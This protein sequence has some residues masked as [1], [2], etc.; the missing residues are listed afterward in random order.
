MQR[1][2]ALRASRPDIAAL[3]TSFG[4]S[5]AV[6]AGLAFGTGHAV[7]SGDWVR[8]GLMLYGASPIADYSARTL[9]LQPV[10]QL[11][12]ELIAVR[13]V[14]AGE[15]IGYGG[16]FRCAQDMRVG[17]VAC[18]YADG[19][20]RHAPTGTP[21]RVAGRTTRLLGRVSMD[22]LCVDLDGLADAG[23]GSP[24]ELFGPGLPVDEIAL[25]ADTIPYEILTAIARR[26]PRRVY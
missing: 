21:V 17:I 25:A 12:S 24:V 3:P 8:P 2:D 5:A 23:V 18:G 9:G 22:M 7:Q 6:T 19:Y 16:S 13:D 14:P 1:M 4:N 26:V 11:C 15:A 20:P 10:M